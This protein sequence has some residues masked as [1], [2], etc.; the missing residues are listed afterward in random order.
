MLGVWL[1]M[2]GCGDSTGGAGSGPAPTSTSSPAPESSAATTTPAPATSTP[3]LTT[4]TT[5]TTEWCKPPTGCTATTTT[6][7]TTTTIPIPVPAASTVDELLALD[8]PVVAAHAGG[9][10][11][12]PHS[13]PYAFSR[14]AFDGADL[15]ELDVQLSGDGMLIV[16]HD[17][18]VDRTTEATGRVSDLTLAEIQALDNAYWFVPG[19]WGDQTR[20]ESEYVFRGIRTGSVEPPFGFS[21]D[22][23]AVATFRQIA[24]RFEDHVLDVEIKLQRGSDGTEDPAAGIAAAEVLAREIAE[25]DRRDSVIV[26][27]FNNEVLEAF[28]RLAPGVAT[29]PGQDAMLDWFW[30]R[31]PFHPADRVIQIPHFFEGK[32]VA[33]PELFGPVQDEGYEVWVWFSGSAVVETAALYAE[34]FSRGIDGV[35]AGRPSLAVTAAHR[36]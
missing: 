9:D 20:P 12:Y 8:R 15:L 7:T 31:A 29:S 35:I 11:D 33:V 4:T 25:L 22:D 14:A 23:F 13:T 24:E 16:Q 28:R 3:V 17:D 26:A 6:T 32:D 27:S 5:P 34:L 1:L 21:A 30:T 18:T 36:R 10:Q 2:A 19:L